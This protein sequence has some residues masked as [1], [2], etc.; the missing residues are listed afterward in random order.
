MVKNR[1]KYITS[2]RKIKLLHNN[3]NSYNVINIIVVN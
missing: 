3:F 2:I 1:L